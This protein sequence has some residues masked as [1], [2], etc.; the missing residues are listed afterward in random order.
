MAFLLMFYTWAMD[1]P[2]T[3]EDNSF[4][5]RIMS[6][7]ISVVN[8]VSNVEP[9]PEISLRDENSKKDLLKEHLSDRSLSYGST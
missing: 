3:T 4:F 6:V 7:L 1:D 5:Y 8:K 9:T 2:N